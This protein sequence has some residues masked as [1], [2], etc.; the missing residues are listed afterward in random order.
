MTTIE[1]D[2]EASDIP[3]ASD[4][5]YAPV[6]V[7]GLVAATQKAL[8]MN[9]G[10]MDQDHRDGIQFKRIMNTPELLAER[11]KLD[12]TGSFRRIMG[13]AARHRSLKGFMPGAL[14]DLVEKHITGSQ[15][16]SPLEEINPLDVLNQARRVTL[17]GPGGISSADMITAPM[18]C[19]SSDTEVLTRRGWKF[20]PAVVA[21]DEMACRVDGV[22]QFHK[23]TRLMSYEYTGAMCQMKT[24]N[25]GFLVTPN[26]RMWS[27]SSARSATAWKWEL[28]ENQVGKFRSYLGSSEPY[29]GTD[30]SDFF[31]LPQVDSHKLGTGQHK[32]YAPIAMGDWCE[33]LGW[34]MSE[35]SHYNG[36]DSNRHTVTLTQSKTANP[37][38]WERISQLTKRLPFAFNNGQGT[39]RNF[40]T[41]SKDLF[42][43][44]APFGKCTV[45]YLP[46]F[47]FE[48]KPEYRRRFL[49]A[50]LAGDGWTQ[51]SGSGVYS[52]SSCR[53]VDDLERLL[54][55][56]GSSVTRGTPWRAKNRAGEPASWMHRASELTR[57]N[58]TARGHQITSEFYAGVVYCAEV[59]GS[60]LLTR[61]GKISRPLWLG[62]SVHASIFG[63]LSPSE[64]PESGQAGVDTRMANGVKI[65]SNGR[66]YQRFRNPRTGDIH[67]LSPE[68]LR[69]KVVGLPG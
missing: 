68:D 30:A 23:P 17:M 41:T 69:G 1:N 26:H 12:S 46:D 35:G 4:D 50:F 48:V 43:Y 21:S 8:A 33:F 7:G 39:S 19:Y 31:V 61:R 34:Y 11:V 6:G 16:S 66:L 63:F 18:Q 47:L 10:L 32:H 25:C 5:Q 59:P 38:K 67:W 64:G 55:S 13:H 36:A 58:I 53:L 56:M 62:N 40:K 9:R 49:K 14:S 3:S 60:L 54:L 65:G 24:F 45:K 29:P 15:L 2:L 44:V 20:W 51:K 57:T 37:A 42:F 52:S 22:L 28:A 27:A